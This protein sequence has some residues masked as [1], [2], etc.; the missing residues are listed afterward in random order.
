MIRANAPR[1]AIYAVSLVAGAALWEFVGN[2]ADP[3]FLVP[4]SVTLRRLVDMMADGQLWAALWSSLQVFGIG[5]L[6][7][8]VGGAPIGLLLAR[9]RFLREGA[10]DYVTAMYATPMVALIPF[11]LAIFGYGF[12]PKVIV[13]F[14]FTVFPMIIN[15]F[16]GARSVDP[17]YL[18]VA[19]SFRAGEWQLWRDVVLPYTLPFAMTGVRLSIAR[20]LV[21]MI[22]AEFFL[23]VSGLGEL[24]L[25][26][27]RRFETATVYAAILVVSLL[28]VVLMNVGQRLEDHFAA[29]K[30]SR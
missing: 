3:I 13:V 2:R 4:L 27:S 12:L 7:G 19:R 17:R 22:A 20:G 29:W 18:E 23:A 10:E 11:I 1:Y 16:E 25:V 21:G 6:A 26:A 28:G 9:I 30:V 5:L 14:L 8:V 24:I 15:V